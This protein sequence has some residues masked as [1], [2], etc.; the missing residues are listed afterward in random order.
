MSSGSAGFSG[1]TAAIPPVAPY[2]EG[3]GQL[4]DDDVGVKL[5]IVDGDP[6]PTPLERRQRLRGRIAPRLSDMALRLAL[7]EGGWVRLD[8]R[9]G[10]LPAEAIDAA[11]LIVDRLPGERPPFLAVLV[12]LASPASSARE[13]GAGEVMD[14][15]MPPV[16]HFSA[17]RVGEMMVLVPVP[18]DLARQAGPYRAGTPIRL[19]CEAVI[20]PHEGPPPGGLGP[21]LMV[22]GRGRAELAEAGRVQLVEGAW[23]LAGERRFLLAGAQDL[24]EGSLIL[25]G[26]SQ[27]RS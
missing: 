22:R 21:H 24:P 16:R 5:E 2:G 18:T 9:S 17:P 23:V 12:H 20:G 19:R 26:F 25:A 6:V 15:P 27:A 10:R 11:R 4:R 8:V 7:D 14:D 3:P 1:R 13:D